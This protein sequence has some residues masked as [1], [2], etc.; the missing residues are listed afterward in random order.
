MQ[1]YQNSYQ[2][3]YQTGIHHN[4]GYVIPLS[5]THESKYNL[6]QYVLRQA[7]EEWEQCKLTWATTEVEHGIWERG[8]SRS[9]V[10]TGFYDWHI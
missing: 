3:E 9:F 6:L 8:K 2:P 4:S 5:M 7:K 10:D 1:D